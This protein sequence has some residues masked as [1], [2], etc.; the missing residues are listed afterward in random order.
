MEHLFQG[1]WFA[2]FREFLEFGKHFSN[3]IFSLLKLTYLLTLATSKMLNLFL[4]VFFNGQ[5]MV[6]HKSPGEYEAV[7]RNSPIGFFKRH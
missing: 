7:E 6:R 4:L 1:H 5:K 3:V 2:F